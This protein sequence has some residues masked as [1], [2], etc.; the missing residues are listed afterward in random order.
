MVSDHDNNVETK[1]LPEQIQDATDKPCPQR[2]RLLSILGVGIAAA[3]VAPTLFSVG[4]AQARG[5]RGDRGGHGSYNRG[6]YYN[7][8]GSYKNRSYSRASG[9]DGQRR[10]RIREYSEDPVLII[11]DVI[12]GPP[13]R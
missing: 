8:R 11:E 1:Q 13:R 12:L 6:S 5:W 2:R 7:N 4:E 3:Y 10:S 9:Y